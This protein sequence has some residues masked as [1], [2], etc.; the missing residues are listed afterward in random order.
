MRRT[1]AQLWIGINAAIS[2]AATNFFIAQAHSSELVELNLNNTEIE[3]SVF[4]NAA[5]SANDNLI[6]WLPSEHG[7]PDSIFNTAQ[8]LSQ[9]HSIS[10][11]WVAKLLSSLFLPAQASSIAKISNDMLYQLL[12]KLQAKT[13]KRLFIVASGK[14]ALLAMRASHFWLQDN[15]TKQQFGGIILLHP[16]LLTKTPEPGS[17]ALYHP[18]THGVT[19]PIFIM[20]P[21]NSPW[22]WQL[23]TLQQHLITANA[24]PYISIL[25]K[26]RD[27]FFF[28]PDATEY[29]QQATQNLAT[30][31]HTS[32]RYL[33][34]EP[35]INYARPAKL[36]ISASKQT[37]KQ[38]AKL[39][40]YTKNPTPPPLNLKDLAG[41]PR[42]LQQHR[43][44]VLVVNFWASWC[45]PCVHEMPSME[46]LY[47][48]YPRSDFTIL[49]VNMA[50]DH[51]T[52]TEF[53]QNRVRVSF[54]ILLDSDGKALQDWQVF[55][56]PSSF[57][58]DKQGKIRYALFGSILWDTPQVY[59]IIDKLIK[60]PQVMD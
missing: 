15:L 3:F 36:P 37:K 44:K 41:K 13:K 14:G 12:K 11:V 22:R 5:N 59:E 32:T 48:R 52:I 34:S 56:F 57:V 30:M 23:A 16:N 4:S 2:I 24:R 46:T 45:P 20:Q 35:L 8:A 31:I 40:R 21:E 49:A 54:P 7:L 17:T 10:Q 9:K 38:L 18:V 58:I 50:E 33:A 51:K 26:V 19:V 43:G 6:L 39:R 53:I 1:L 28:R 25:P 29:E 55:A 47:Q 27:R 42:S 60:E